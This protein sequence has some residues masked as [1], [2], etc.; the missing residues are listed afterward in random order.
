ML[1]TRPGKL[2][3]VLYSALG[4][5][6]FRCEFPQQFE[7]RRR[8]TDKEAHGRQELNNAHGNPF[9]L[10]RPNDGAWREASTEKWTGLRHDQVGLKSLSA[11]RLGVEVR[12]CLLYT[13]PSPRDS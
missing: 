10:G 8:L 2:L 3:I 12:D 6:G 4:V 9:C 1:A 7:E 11:K 13:S 5:I